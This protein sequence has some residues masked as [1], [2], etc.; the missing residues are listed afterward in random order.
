MDGNKPISATSHGHAL[1][2]GTI[3]V[4]K[5]P[6]H[7]CLEFLIMFTGSVQQ[8]ITPEDSS[9]DVTLLRRKNLVTA[10]SG[11]VKFPDQTLGGLR[12]E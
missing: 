8:I 7:P 9:A 1:T 11:T 3:I 2:S 5:V 6:F 10:V 4:A 12:Y